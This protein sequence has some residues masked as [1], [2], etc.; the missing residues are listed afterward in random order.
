MA[1]NQATVYFIDDESQ[2]LSAL[3]RALR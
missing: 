2:V 1:M 3:R